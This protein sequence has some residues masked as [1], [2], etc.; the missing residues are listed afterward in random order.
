M[1]MCE[2]SSEENPFLD[3]EKFYLDSGRILPQIFENIASSQSLSDNLKMQIAY[4]NLEPSISEVIN[5]I[6]ELIDRDGYLRFSTDELK[7]LTHADDS[8]LNS[9]LKIIQSLEPPGI[10]ARN[11]LE[12]LMLQLK[13]KNLEKSL[14]YKVIVECGN[15]LMAGK[16]SY[17]KKKMKLNDEEIS[18]V[19]SEIGKLDPFPARVLVSSERVVPK[20]PDITIKSI[21]PEVLI[22]FAEDRIFRISIN[23]NYLRL[24]KS[25]TFTINEKNFLNE[26]LRQARNLIKCIETRKKFLEKVFMFIIEYQ[27][28]FIQK[29]GPLKPLSEKYLSEKFSCSFSLIS[30]AVSDKYVSSGTG[31]F[32]VKSLFSYSKDKMSQ[33]FIIDQ[34]EDIIKN[35][36]ISISDRKIAEKLKERGISI[37]TRTVNKYRKKRKILNSYIRRSLNT[38]ENL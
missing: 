6:I 1:Q 7:S 19:I 23:E 36:D 30:R 21:E 38:L 16:F 13:A 25:K 26:K 8:T 14:A 20:Y 28:D 34:I 27:K 4:L 37:A 24:L 33:A 5:F 22:E 15:H 10:G 31:I 17:I 11:L 18:S 29:K 9:A 35:T 3:F 12:C 2:E 32:P